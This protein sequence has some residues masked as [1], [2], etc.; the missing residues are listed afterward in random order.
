MPV[1]RVQIPYGVPRCV[2]P[3]WLAGALPV[4]WAGPTFRAVYGDGLYSGRVARKMAVALAAVAAPIATACTP[5]PPDGG[6]VS[7]G[8]QI[9]PAQLGSVS[10]FDVSVGDLQKSWEVT[11]PGQPSYAVIAAD[12]VMVTAKTA[13]AGY[14]TTLHALSA[15]DG[16]EPWSRDLGGTYWWSGLATEGGVVFALNYDG[17][18]RAFDVGNGNQLWQQQLPQYSYS[19]PPTVLDGVVYALG[20]GSGGTLSAVD[21]ATGQISWNVQ[22]AGHID[23]PSVDDTGVY[24]THVCDATRISLD[25]SR[26]WSVPSGCSGGGGKHATLDSARSHFY[27]R[28]YGSPRGTF[29]A[30]T[31]PEPSASRFRTT[32]RTP[33]TATLRSRLTTAYS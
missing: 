31:E 27:V 5:P 19:A 23:A 29:I 18:L 14:G 10:D 16:S 26:V 4:R 6:T 33:S 2:T 15:I 3:L 30:D 21:A 8:F 1:A 24:V 22:A 11:F 17:V 20:A 25:G 7:S 32:R 9:D 13:V 28:N 12:T